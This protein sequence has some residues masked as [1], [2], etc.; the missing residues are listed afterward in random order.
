MKKKTMILGTFAILGVFA[1]SSCGKA[2]FDNKTDDTNTTPKTTDVTT[3][4][5]V[6]PT[7]A[8]GTTPITAPTAPIITTTT[9]TLTVSTPVEGQVIVDRYDFSDQVQSLSHYPEEL[10]YYQVNVAY[11]MDLNG[12]K[13]TGTFV[14]TYDLDTKKWSSENSFAEDNKYLINYTITSR[15]GNPFSD[16]TFYLNP[17]AVLEKDSD[18]GEL[19]AYFQWN[20][21]GLISIF[22][23]YNWTELGTSTFTY[24]YIKS[25]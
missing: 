8:T 14:Y 23:T 5:G 19:E 21:E 20:D 17:Y 10:G 4:T 3:T 15:V 2:N 9:S 1:L 25:K 7:E 22:K 11:D 6:K 13:S 16:M 12:Q 24:T 18:T